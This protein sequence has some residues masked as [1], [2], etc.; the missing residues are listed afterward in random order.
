MVKKQKHS[1]AE[2][3]YIQWNKKNYL[4]LLEYFLIAV[5]IS[6]VMEIL[7][8]HSFLDTFHYAVT[9]PAAF[10][11]DIVIVFFTLSASL[12][13]SKRKFFL[14]LI[15]GLWLGVAVANCILLTFRSMPLTA[16]DIWLLSSVRDI[17]EK[18]LS[19]V[20]LIVLMLVISFLVALIIGVFLIVKKE[21]GHFIFGLVHF[22]VLGLLLFAMTTSFIQL[23]LID[24]TTE[25]NSLPLAYDRNGFAYCFAASLVTGGIDEP[26]DYSPIEVEGIIDDTIIELPTTKSDTPNIVFVQLES[27]FDANYMQNLTMARNPVPNFQALKQKYPSGL[28]SVPCIGAGTANTEFEVLTGMNLSHFGVGEYPYMT[29]VDSASSESI[30]SVLSA[31]GYA[32]HAI[33]NN[34]ATFYDRHIVYENLAFETFTSLEYMSAVE[35]NPLG[36]AKDTV[37]TE[38]ILKCLT[39]SEEK[40]LVFTVSVQPHGKY[41]T[42]LPEGAGSIAVEGLDEGRQVGF[43]YYLQELYECDLFIGELVSALEG[44]E[45]DTIVV[46]YGD[47]LPSFNIQN[48]ELSCGDNQTT[49]YVIWANFPLEKS[50]RDLQTYQLSAYALQLAGIYEGTIFRLHQSYQ[51][52]EEDS[53]EYQDD[54]QIL[55]YD[56]IYGEKYYAEGEPQKEPIPL[57]FDVEDVTLLDVVPDEENAGYR[58]RGEN[59]TPFSVVY[60]D[61]E[62]YETSFLSETELLITEETI[63]AGERICIMQVSA[64]DEMVILSQSNALIWV[65]GES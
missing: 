23:D 35:Y 32:T 24:S 56:M 41:P 16:S 52:R 3:M 15:S 30:A 8:R 4:L 38:E 20:G 42:E 60:I 18:Y 55:E 33:H 13:F 34:N 5:C 63:E 12:L 40:D 14:A 2:K 47:H 10:F 36:W 51:F 57:R 58:I 54:L 53:V 26:V 11:F 9:R 46:F 1:F 64:S 39:V 62:P 37:L 22:S 25:F 19:H 48:D 7:G 61:D 50:V 17:F 59:F 65:D 21:K 45:E 31:L 28:L 49:E 43:S 44:Y 27:F 29:I 6:T